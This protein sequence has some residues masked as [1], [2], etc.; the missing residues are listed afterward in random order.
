M[1]KKTLMSTLIVLSF[2]AH[3]AIDNSS[4]VA[5]DYDCTINE[6][7]SYMGKKTE[8][9]TQRET[10]IAP[11]DDFQKGNVARTS[12]ANAGG[13]AAAEKNPDGTPKEECNYFWGDLDDIKYEQKDDSGILDAILSGDIGG[14][15]NASKERV[16]EVATGMTDEIKKGVCKRLST[17]NVKKTV[18]DY[19][20][21]ALKDGTGYGVDDV[22]DPD[23]NGFV[24]DGLKGG[25]GN[26]GKLINVFDPAQDKNRA[27]VIL[28]ETDRQA[29]EMM[30]MD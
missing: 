12:S 7:Q 18:I 24:N 30:K 9:M 8:S 19:G 5:N 1:F 4:K 14:L 11:F 29:K 23:L 28:K 10:A 17:E 21:D 22:T 20:D 25:F 27:N 16:L 26:T 2:S 3:A 13:A 15:V 6:L